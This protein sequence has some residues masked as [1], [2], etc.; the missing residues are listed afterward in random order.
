MAV[1][2][3]SGHIPSHQAVI[4]TGG[5]VY[6]LDGSLS[7]ALQPGAWHQRG[8]I[9]G[10]SLFVRTAPPQ[11]LR[12]I[13]RRG[14]RPPPID[15]VSSS[16]NS[17]TIRVRAPTPLALVRDVAWDKGWGASVSVNGRAARSLPVSAYGMVQQVDL[18][19]G[20]DVVT[21]RYRPAHFV[22]AGVLSAA[23]VLFLL[24]LGAVAAIRAGRRRN[25]TAA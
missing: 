25:S 16:A 14:Q 7:T 13:T 8:S 3:V 2:V 20:R 23:A 6:E 22:I 10:Q 19:S 9:D 4:R 12:A 1:Q 24:V 5:H 18:P 15:V 17:E 11:P 21:F